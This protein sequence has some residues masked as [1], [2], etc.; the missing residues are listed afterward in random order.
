VPGGQQNLERSP[1]SYL[2]LPDAQSRSLV[3]HHGYDWHGPGVYVLSGDR[4]L[5][6]LW[7]IHDDMTIGI[8]VSPY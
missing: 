6:G 2:Y 5:K 4:P 8:A 3:Q 1:K 7:F